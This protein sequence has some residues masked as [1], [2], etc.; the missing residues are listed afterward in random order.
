M[1]VYAR[2]KQHARRHR[3]KQIFLLKPIILWCLSNQAVACRRGGG[4]QTG[5]RPRA[6]KVGGIKRVKFQKL[7]FI[8]LLKIYAFLYHKSTNTSCMDLIQGRSQ[9][10]I[11]RGPNFATF[12]VTSF[13]YNGILPFVNYAHR[14][15]KNFCTK[16]RKCD[17]NFTDL[18]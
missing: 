8:K 11:E 18:M 6:S 2:T 4:G 9:K 12:N 17:C 7:H 5:R 10:K 13:T 1:C 3:R 16:Q 14:Y 15:Y